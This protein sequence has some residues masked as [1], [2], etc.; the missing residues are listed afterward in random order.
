MARCAAITRAGEPC[1]GVVSEGASYCPA[2]DPA[3]AE[4]RKRAAKKGGRSRVGGG[5]LSDIRREVR[6]VIGGVLNGQIEKGA[7]ATALQGF[8]VLLRAHEL[9]QKADIDELS[10]E[11]EELKKANASGIGRAS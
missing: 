9:S 6:A 1:K 8:N 3:Q 7:G 2:H 4:R 10:R 5:E 11:V